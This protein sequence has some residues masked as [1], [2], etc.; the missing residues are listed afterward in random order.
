MLL[1]HNGI[2]HS[3]DSNDPAA[4][5][6]LVGDDGRILAVGSLAEVE[7]AAKPGTKRVNLEG[8]TLIPGFNDAHVHIWKMGLLLTRQVIA[9]KA[10]APDIE[11]IIDRF[12]HKADSLPAGTW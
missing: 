5:A 4:E 9:N 10:T 12:R 6:L 3:L 1:F 2:I 7:A 11:S 8:R